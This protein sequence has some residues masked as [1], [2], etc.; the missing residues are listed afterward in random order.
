MVYEDGALSAGPTGGQIEAIQ[1]LAAKVQAL[2]EEGERLMEPLLKPQQDREKFKQE[3]EGKAAEKEK[4]FMEISKALKDKV[5]SLPAKDDKD[6]DSKLKAAVVDAVPVGTVISDDVLKTTSVTAAIEAAK[7]KEMLVDIFAD[8]VVVKV[9]SKEK[10]ADKKF[11]KV[12]YENSNV[13]VELSE[14]DPS[15][16]KA[17]AP[18]TVEDEV[19]A[20]ANAQIEA[21]RKELSGNQSLMTVLGFFGLV[22][23]K[24]DG[25]PDLDA[26]V[27]DP[28]VKLVGWLFG[29][30]FAKGAIDPLVKAASAKWPGFGEKVEGWK[31]EL[32]GVLGSVLP[33]TPMNEIDG[34][35]K[36]MPAYSTV[37]KA[38]GLEKSSKTKEEE[39]VKGGDLIINVPAGKT[40]TFNQQTPLTV[41]F[42]K[43]GSK[44]Y[45][46]GEKGVRI[47]GGPDI[48]IK[49]ATGYVI[50]AG[51]TFDQGVKV[52]MEKG[53]EE[54]AEV[55]AKAPTVAS[56][57][58]TKGEAPTETP[59]A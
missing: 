20:K 18:K 27:K 28:V 52:W 9:G 57:D 22:K 38:S 55:E 26:A 40:V 11:F 8:D 42:V 19:E 10:L 33:E 35:V 46:A 37:W 56:E 43:G 48:E 34:L 4:L 21:A 32:R 13:V 47:E 53:K 41:N 30:E 6:F 5:L 54:V 25:N 24:E 7:A 58:A 44:S 51:S 12:K 29:A 16:V 39:I 45:A 14:Q 49:L 59:A 31:K 36:D 15:T 17:E 3:L 1:G 23:N 50:P 2:Q